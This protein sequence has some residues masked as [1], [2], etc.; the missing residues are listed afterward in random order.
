MQV[1]V[2]GMFFEDTLQRFR[3][4]GV[5]RFFGCLFRV[6]FGVVSVAQLVSALDCGSRGWGFKSPR[7]PQFFLRP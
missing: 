2:L 3:L 1:F 5:Q 7:S 6:G 4:S